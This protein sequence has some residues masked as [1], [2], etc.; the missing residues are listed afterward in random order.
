M[1][2]ILSTIAAAALIGST[3]CVTPAAVKEA[4]TRH[5]T[6]LESIET[7]VVSYRKSIAAYY[8]RLSVLQR[9]AYVAQH[10]TQFIHDTADGQAKSLKKLKADSA[11]DFIQA[12]SEIEGGFEFW[13]SNFDLWM[14]QEGAT[15][16]EKR[17]NLRTKAKKFDDTGKGQAAAKLRAEAGRSNDDLTYIFVAIEL[18]KQKSV[19]GAQLDLLAV[20]V[21]TMQEFHAK[22]DEFLSIDATIDGTKIAEAAAAGSNV[23]LSD[24]HGSGGQ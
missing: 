19:L 1:R 6:N 21:D 20:Q 11:K 24:L 2:L 12:G 15:L 9:D 17:N 10:M 14:K 5:K 8:D 4:S 18:Q 16:D 13:A 23:D 3:G 22:I 7:A